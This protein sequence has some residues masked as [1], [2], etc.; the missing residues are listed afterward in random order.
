MSL[1]DGI[2]PRKVRTILNGI[3]QERFPFSGS[4]PDGSVVT[5][6]RLSPEKDIANLVQA[7]A[8]VRQSDP[9]LRIEVAGDGPCRGELGRLVGELGLDGCVSFLG[10]IHDVPALLARGAIFVLPSRSE[11]ISLTLLEAMACGL[12][13]VATRVGGTPE[14]VVDGETGLLVPPADPAALAEAV[15]QAAARPR[16][17]AADGGSRPLPYRGRL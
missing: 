16:G 8:I 2:A 4:A 1:A 3:D 6:A 12:P 11:G 5:V 15:L 7:A 9:D 13:V 17:C 14:V 10:E